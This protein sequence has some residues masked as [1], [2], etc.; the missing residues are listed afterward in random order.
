MQI[1][2][3]FW[4]CIDKQTATAEQFCTVKKI[5][6][7]KLNGFELHCS[8]LHATQA[9]TV[10]RVVVAWNKDLPCFS[11]DMITFEHKVTETERIGYKSALLF[12]S[13]TTFNC[14]DCDDVSQTYT[15]QW[16]QR[17]VQFNQISNPL[18]RNHIPADLFLLFSGICR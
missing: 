12:S 7:N 18:K 2:N 6:K 17:H 11:L 14:D 13:F 3:S 4:F 16:Q 9:N 15:Q 5:S 8:C 1:G 10:N